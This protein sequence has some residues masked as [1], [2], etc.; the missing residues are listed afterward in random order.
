VEIKWPT[1]NKQKKKAM[2]ISNKTELK[3]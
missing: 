3:M 2:I 1:N